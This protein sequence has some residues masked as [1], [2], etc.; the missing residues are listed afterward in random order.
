MHHVLYVTIGTAVS[1]DLL[2][3]KPYIHKVLCISNGIPTPTLTLTIWHIE[4]DNYRVTGWLGSNHQLA[5]KIVFMSWAYILQVLTLIFAF[6]VCDTHMCHFLT[7]LLDLN[8]LITAE[9]SATGMP[10]TCIWLLITDRSRPS[11][12]GLT[13]LRQFCRAGLASRTIGRRKTR[14]QISVLQCL[15]CGKEQ[16]AQRIRTIATATEEL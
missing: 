5:N 3:H 7:C 10:N 4:P 11:A 1:Q 6:T 14:P 2:C 16:N 8:S 15:R 9:T 13:T 12:K